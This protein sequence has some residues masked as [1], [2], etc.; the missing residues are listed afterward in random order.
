MQTWI[1]ILNLLSNICLSL[2]YCPLKKL[3]C[4][5]L[6]SKTSFQFQF[7]VEYILQI[8]L[9]LGMRRMA[10]WYPQIWP[11][12]ILKHST[13]LDGLAKD[14]KHDIRQ[15][16]G[17]SLWS[18]EIW[19]DEIKEP[20]SQD[21]AAQARKS[22]SPNS[23]LSLSNSWLWDHKPGSSHCNLQFCFDNMAW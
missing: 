4:L 12:F 21:S 20:S 18:L 7:Y 10:S 23:D 3:R 11:R 17:N 2:S 13:C 14:D 8:E 22:D 19:I 16:Q 6:I 5:L 9:S 1:Y 15:L